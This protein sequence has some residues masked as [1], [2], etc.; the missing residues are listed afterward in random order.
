MA[1]DIRTLCIIPIESSLGTHRV[2]GKCAAVKGDVGALVRQDGAAGGALV[3]D[4]L[5]GA[6]RRHRAN[7]NHN[8]AGVRLQHGDNTSVCCSGGM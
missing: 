5:R 8:G 4:K 6:K 2:L 1:D 7:A 3:A